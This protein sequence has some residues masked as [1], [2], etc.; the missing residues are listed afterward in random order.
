MVRDIQQKQYD[1]QFRYMRA[2]TN[3]M[4]KMTVNP[5][6]APMPIQYHFS[7]GKMSNCFKTATP[8]LVTLSD[9]CHRY[10]DLNQDFDLFR[11]YLST[12]LMLSHSLICSSILRRTSRSLQRSCSRSSEEKSSNP[13]STRLEF[14]LHK[15]IVS[16]GTS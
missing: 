11:S 3:S 13:I 9:P 10:K 14:D 16:L 8:N 5:N 2:T 12:I 7:S 1:L 15:A 6:R 4:L